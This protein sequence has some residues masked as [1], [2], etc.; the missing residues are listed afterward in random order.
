MRRMDLFLLPLPQCA[1]LFQAAGQPLFS[2]AHQGMEHHHAPDDGGRDE[3]DFG[4]L[5]EVL[6]DKRDVSSDRRDNAW[7]K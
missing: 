4:R 5:L 2:I 7:P 6:Q 3:Q 1:D